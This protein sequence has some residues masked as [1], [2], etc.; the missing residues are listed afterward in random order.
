MNLAG[1]E[2]RGHFSNSI[3]NGSL[4]DDAV[5]IL[6]ITPQT[7]KRSWLGITR[8][9]TKKQEKEMRFDKYCF[10]WFIV[11]WASAAIFYWMV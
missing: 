11:G 1:A 5:C 4:A 7:R 10:M 6:K 9:K 3:Y 8:I 2:V